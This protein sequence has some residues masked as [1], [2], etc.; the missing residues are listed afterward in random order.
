MCPHHSP[1]LPVS[2]CSRVHCFKSRSR[3]LYFIQNGMM[4]A[5]FYQILFLID[6]GRY[7]TTW[8]RYR[9]VAEISV[10][11]RDEYIRYIAT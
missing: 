2:P 7:I 6:M 5:K 3:Y 9:H 1:S 8:L 10:D 4:G 11:I